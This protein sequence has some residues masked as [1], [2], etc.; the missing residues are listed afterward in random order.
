[1]NDKS[2]SEILNSL[3]ERISDVMVRWNKTSPNR[4]C[5]VENGGKWTYGELSAAVDEAQRWLAERGVRAGDRV[6]IVC[7][8]C[9]AFVAVLLASARLD[10]WPVLVNARLSAREVDQIREHCGARLI[11]YT[12]AVSPRARDHARRQGAVNEDLEFLGTMALTGANEL[13]S[14]ESLDANPVERVAAV[15][16]TSGTTGRPKGVMLTHQN[17]LYIAAGSARIRRLT[18]GDRILGVL[19]MSHAVGLSVV[20]LGTLLSGATLYL[21]QRFDPVAT[22]KIIED[23]RLTVF[24]GVPSMFAL[25]VQYA[26]MKKIRSLRCPALRII[27]SSGAP[28][29]PV[30][31]RDVEDLLGIPLH[32]GY[33]VTECS[34]TIAQADVDEPCRGTSVGRVFPGVEIKIVG[35]DGRTVAEGEAGELR[36][37]GPNVMKGYYR[38]P[39]DTRAVIDPDGWFNTRDLARLEDGHLY[40]IGRTQELIIRFGFNVYPAEVEAVLA[41]HPAVFRC[42]VVGKST[43]GAEDELIIAFVQPV[44]C[45]VITTAD[46]SRYAAQ[47]LAAYKV[48]TEICIVRELPLTSTG[49]I[50]KARLAEMTGHGV[51]TL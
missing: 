39:D 7:E 10:A 31:K 17:L 27:S 36:V 12:V 11:V 33:G 34:P 9:R 24:L 6:M 47:H 3:P 25:L 48:P 49:E 35:A 15:I 42:A 5:L 51:P 22:C 38:S 19:P 14:P 18:P 50:S 37:R 32:N 1:M 20:L 40:I 2:A 21:S 23:D 13:V 26:R 30:L 29:Q 16:Y 4:I 44:P 8:N 43:Q 28:L 41:S 45:S 46:L